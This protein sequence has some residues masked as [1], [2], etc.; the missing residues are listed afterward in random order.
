MYIYMARHIPYTIILNL[1]LIF[2]LINIVR[3]SRD[4][5]MYEILHTYSE[6]VHRTY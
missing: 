1:L 3:V 4:Y 2:L 5:A 6:V